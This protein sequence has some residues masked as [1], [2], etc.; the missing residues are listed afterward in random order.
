MRPKHETIAPTM[1]PSPAGVSAADMVRAVDPWMAA[2]V[3]LLLSVGTVLVYSAS[4]V[5]AHSASGHSDLYLM[6]HLASIAVGLVLMAIV[7]R[8]PIETWSRLAYPMLALS[9]VLLIAV[10]IPGLGRRVNGAMR[11]ISLGPASFQPAEFA[12]L[13]VV[14]YLAHSLAKKREKASSFS[15]GF[16]PHVAITSAVVGLILIQPDIGTSAVIFATLGFMLFVAG[17]RISYLVLAVVGALP[18]AIHYVVTRPHAFKRILV[19]MEPEAYKQNIGYQVWESLVSFG[20]GG[21]FGLGLGAGKQKLYFLPESHTDFI[22]AVL[23]QE[24]GFLGV[25][26]AVGAFVTLVGRGLWLAS[27]LP[28]RFPMFLVFGLSVWLGVQAATNM[29]VV[30]ALLPTKGLTLPLVSFGRSS[31]VITMVAVA[32]LLRASAEARTQLLRLASAPARPRTRR[33]NR[34]EALA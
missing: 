7:M 28:C 4:A 26:L 21:A 34:K 33:V 27:K 2:A 30:T 29:A 11:W 22:F 1:M 15:I 5:R 10:F 13:A 32:I 16:V 14:V 3:V 8:I 12:K 23:G 24:L 18:V 17:T 20:S 25:V 6:R 19:F 9:V 31:L